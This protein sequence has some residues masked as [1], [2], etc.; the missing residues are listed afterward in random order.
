MDLCTPE[1]LC[2]WRSIWRLFSQKEWQKITKFVI[3]TICWR[4][5]Q[6]DRHRTDAPSRTPPSCGKKSS[7]W[8]VLRTPHS[9]KVTV[10]RRRRKKLLLH[11]FQPPHLPGMCQ[12]RIL[13][14]ASCGS[15]ALLDGPRGPSKGGTPG[16]CVKFATHS[17]NLVPAVR[18]R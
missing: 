16:F 4:D 15:W 10:A 3:F 2:A 6:T 12:E 1:N 18:A 17:E 7:P 14:R 5:T 8:A 13:L 11:H 9:N